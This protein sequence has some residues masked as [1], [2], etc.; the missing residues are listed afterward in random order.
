VAGRVVR[1]PAEVPAGVMTALV[2]VPVLVV[3]VRR[4][5]VAS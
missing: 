3:L 4:K 5:G 2:G 1:A